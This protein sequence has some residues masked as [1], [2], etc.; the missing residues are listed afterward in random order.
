MLGSMNQFAR[1]GFMSAQVEVDSPMLKGF[2][3]LQNP[4]TID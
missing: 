4:Q 1:V 2:M 3:N